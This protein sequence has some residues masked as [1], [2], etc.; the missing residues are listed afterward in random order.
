MVAGAGSVRSRSGFPGGP[1]VSVPYGWGLWSL[2]CWF[3]RSRQRT[4]ML[5]SE[6]Q[7]HILKYSRGLDEERNFCGL[8][9][10]HDVDA[11]GVEE[12]QLR[13]YR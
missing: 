1:S 4:L 13:D 12:P 2:D 3:P 10:D 9:S 7:Q 8:L 5:I 6:M 11:A